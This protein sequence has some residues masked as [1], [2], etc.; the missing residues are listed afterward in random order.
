MVNHY[1]SR[2]HMVCFERD[3][4]DMRDRGEN[5][6]SVETGVLFRRR[7]LRQVME[8]LMAEKGDCSRL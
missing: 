1:D 7:P 5:S 8:G 4:D 3:K 6:E 2:R